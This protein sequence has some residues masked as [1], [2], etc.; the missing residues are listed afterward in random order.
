[1]VIEPQIY[2]KIWELADKLAKKEAIEVY[3]QPHDGAEVK[4]FREVHIKRM[5]GEVTINNLK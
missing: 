1:M 4:K 5:I 2:E 3:G